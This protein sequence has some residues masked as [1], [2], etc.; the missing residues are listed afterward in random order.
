[1]KKISEKSVVNKSQGKQLV[2]QLVRDFSDN[3]EYF[4]SEQFNETEVRNRFIDP[5]FK[6]LGWEFDQT[7][8]S[9]EFWDVHREYSQKEGSVNK[10]PD[11][12]FRIDGKLKFFTEAKAPHVRLEDKNPAHQAKLL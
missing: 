11:Y 9:P 5:F 7:H 1:M 3:Q 4:L 10:K 6:A 12:A 2:E 8:L